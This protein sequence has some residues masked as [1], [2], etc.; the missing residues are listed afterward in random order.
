VSTL[1]TSWRD[2]STP[3]SAQSTPAAT[4]VG[5]PVATSAPGLTI[6]GEEGNRQGTARNGTRV[7][8]EGYSSTRGV[9]KER[10]L[11]Y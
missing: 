3:V 6:A 11:E 10:V 4:A 8:Q 5:A 9:L 2:Q 7:L 1:S